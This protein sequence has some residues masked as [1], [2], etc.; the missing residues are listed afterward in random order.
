MKRNGLGPQTGNPQN[1]VGVYQEYTYSSFA[2]LMGFPLKSLYARVGVGMLKVGIRVRLGSDVR[3]Q[4]VSWRY[5]LGTG[6]RHPGKESASAGCWGALEHPKM[7][8]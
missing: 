3:V 7:R 1:R 5:Y 4:L 8:R 2:V 6:S